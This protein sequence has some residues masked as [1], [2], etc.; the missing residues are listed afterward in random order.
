LGLGAPA[1]AAPPA[2]R[3]YQTVPRAT[4]TSDGGASPTAT[5]LSDED[6]DEDSGEEEALDPGGEEDVVNE[7]FGSTEEE[8]MVE[9]VV[10]ETYTALV[11]VDNLNMREG[12]GTDFPIAGTVAADQTVTI[13]S[14]NEDGSWWYACCIEGSDRPGWVSAD[15][16]EPNFDRGQAVNLLPL[17]GAEAQVSA[18]SASITPVAPATSTGALQVSLFL[19]PAFAWQGQTTTIRIAVTNPNNAAVTNV[20]LSDELPRGLAYVSAEADAGGQISNEKTPT[21]GVLIRARWANLPPGGTVSALITAQ[22][23][24]DLPDGAVLDNLVAVRS[25]NAAYTTGS[26]IIGMPPALLPTF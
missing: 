4:P 5:P 8:P 26:I 3:L 7:I 19:S 2:E 6:D 20:E 18:A 9:E 16:A 22:V 17:F 21:G 24:P 13:Y 25:A 14:R 23:S 11:T 12:P 15:L 1:W 10:E